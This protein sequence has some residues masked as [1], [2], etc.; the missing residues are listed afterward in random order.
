MKKIA[1]LGPENSYSFLA[2]KRI[3]K[4]DDMLLPYPNFL[5]V[6]D[7]VQNNLCDCAV[8]PVENSIEGAVNEVTDGLIFNRNL[9][10]NVEFS[11]PI[12]NFLIAQAQADFKKIHTIYTH[13]QP[14]GQCRNSLKTQFP[15]ATIV[16]KES[17]SAAVTCIQNPF[18][19][20]IGG[21]HLC[22]MGLQLSDSSLNDTQSNRTRF[23]VVSKKNQ[24]DITHDKFSLAFEVQNRPGALL[25]FLQVLNYQNLNMTHIESRPHKSE[26][27]R[28][29]FIVDVLGNVLNTKVAYALKQIK[30]MTQFYKFLGSYT[31]EKL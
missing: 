24:P 28:Y 29:I 18:C 13:W 17:T 6:L 10:I 30:N 3:M 31:K 16:F 25:E 1:Y 2:A 12:D 14:Y 21:E 5:E 8:V 7:R 20:A 23:V 4:T 27:G 11:I 9:Y 19:A 22:T 26:L 15:N